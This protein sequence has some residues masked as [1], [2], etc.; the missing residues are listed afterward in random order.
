M[1]TIEK[2]DV[3]CDF[4]LKDGFVTGVRSSDDYHFH[5]FFE[6]HYVIRG[7]MDIVIDDRDV[8]L[9][10]GDVCIL[11]PKMVHYIFEDEDSYRVGFRFSFAPAKSGAQECYWKRF[12][13]TFGALKSALVVS[14]CSLFQQCLG[15]SAQALGENAPAYIIDELLFLALDRLSY[16]ILG[17]C[18][19]S[20]APAAACSDGLLSE[21]IEEYLNCHYRSVPK[22][23]EL[24]DAL[25]M[26]IRQT[27]RVILRLFGITFSELLVQKRLTVARFL[28]RTTTLSVEEITHRAGFCD[29]PYFY[30][31]FKACFGITPTQYR[32]NVRSPEVSTS[33]PVCLDVCSG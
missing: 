28:L 12:Q 9:R 16:S 2:E 6:I 32:R 5:S 14:D 22:I 7:K 26:S 11:P 19:V 17:K 25:G 27:Q 18:Y 10:S 15:A 13:D 23:G 1:H 29:K 24:A 4:I 3:V 33:V 21:Y 31:R 20:E 30:R 8:H